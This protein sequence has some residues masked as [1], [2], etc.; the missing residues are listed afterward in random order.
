MQTTDPSPADDGRDEPIAPA[1]TFDRRNVLL[2][3]G[4]HMA[5]DTYP[6]FLGVLLPLLIPKLGISLAAA[7]VIA[8]SLRWTTSAQPFLGVVADRVDTR[9]WVILAPAVT[10]CCMSVVGISPNVGMLVFL[11]LATGLSHAAFHPAG[12]ALA[13]RAA[14]GQWGKAASY[15]MTGGEI[16]RVIGPVFIAG[17]VAVVGLELSWITVFPGLA[18]SLLLFLRFRNAPFLDR[19]GAPPARIGDALRAGRR[20]L[21]LLSAAMAVRSFTNVTFVVYYPTFAV[22]ERGASLLLAGLGLTIYELGAVAGAF[23]GGLLSDRRGR[24][25]VLA[26]GLVAATP[27]LAGAVL[28]GPTLAG[29]GLLALGGLTLLTSASVELVLI[30]ELLPD[31]RSAA[32]GINY[33]MKALGATVA[34]IVVGALGDALGLRDAMLVGIGIGLCALPLTLLIVEPGRTRAASAG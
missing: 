29:L 5:H 21:V 9:Y 12:G 8:S 14:G 34:T 27:L 32:V 1:P 22:S 15:F 3:S 20:P 7:G 30:Q 10:A 13:T 33:F 4:A 23:S 31:N 19:R 25:R 16:G 2:L 28:L 6:A 18:F 17:V 26:I 11:L 24:V